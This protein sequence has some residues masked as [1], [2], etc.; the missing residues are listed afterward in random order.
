MTD[1]TNN[2]AMR[3]KEFSKCIDIVLGKLTLNEQISYSDEKIIKLAAFE[4]ASQQNSD[5]ITKEELQAVIKEL[6]VD[7]EELIAERVKKHCCDFARFY[8]DKFVNSNKSI[9]ESIY[10]DYLTSQSKESADK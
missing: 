4:Y 5:L 6:E 9:P 2:P 3:E 8:Q 1:T 7:L 10:N